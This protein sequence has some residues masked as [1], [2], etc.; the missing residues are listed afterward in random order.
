MYIINRMP[1]SVLGNKSPYQVLCKE[2]VDYSVMRSFGYLSFAANPAH[3]ADKLHARGMPSIFLGYPPTQKGYRLLDLTT[4]KPFVSRDVQFNEA[5]FPFNKNS[6]KSYM[7][8]LPTALPHPSV[9][10]FVDD[11][12]FD[13]AAPNHEAEPE[14]SDDH[15]EESDAQSSEEETSEDVPLRRTTR[16][17]RP[18]SWMQSYVSKPFPSSSTNLV[19]IAS[20]QVGNKFTCFLASLTSKADPKNFNQAVTDENWV[21]AMNLELEA[22]ESNGTWEI[23]VLP[24]NKR[25]IGCQWLYKTKYRSDGEV[26][27]YKSRLVILGNRQV[28]GVDYEHTFAPV[29]K[30]TT[31]RALLDVAAVKNWYVIQM[32]VT[33][34]FLHGDLDEDVHM[35]M[36][37][38]YTH[39]GCRIVLN[40]GE[41]KAAKS[42][43]VCKLKR[44][45]YGLRQAPRNWF[46]KLSVVL[47]S[48]SYTQSIHQCQ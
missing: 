41:S 6:E 13:F 25:A 32:D 23:T 17:T 31:V 35:K 10:T 28:Y 40:Q 12:E 14:L 43:L 47:K 34:A 36:S 11:V 7:T 22:L 21:K 20:Q 15:D 29:A 26:E 27:R 19:T 1:S 38:G 44:S 24:E 45:L 18:P 5:V 9:N 8:P 46:S 48:L 2:D 16:V 4:M 30:M 39:F 3:S 37:H 33:N 42:N